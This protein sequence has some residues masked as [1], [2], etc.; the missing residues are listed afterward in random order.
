ML[1]P[2][3][4]RPGAS[5]QRR[6]AAAHSYLSGCR[7][8]RCRS[9]SLLLWPSAGRILPSLAGQGQP[10][11]LAAT[12]RRQEDTAADTSDPYAATPEDALD[13]A[14]RE[15]KRWR[16]EQLT[17]VSRLATLD[18]L[19]EWF[20]LAW[21]AFGAPQFPYDEALRLARVVGVDLDHEIIGHLAQKKASDAA[22]G[23][24]HA[25]C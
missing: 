12:R 4:G 21:D 7:Y 6:R 23:Q 19:T 16:L 14:R 25:R 5:R 24:H 22:V 3:L 15:V 8:P 20:V 13:T 9:L 18:P 11:P 2:L 1:S 10:R 17:T